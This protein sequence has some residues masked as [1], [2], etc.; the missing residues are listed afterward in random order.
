MPGASLLTA[1]RGWA[2][3]GHVVSM[4]CPPARELAGVLAHLDSP[5]PLIFAGTDTH[6]RNYLAEKILTPPSVEWSVLGDVA[7]FFAKEW[8]GYDRWISGR[9]WKRS[10]E[11][12]SMIDGELLV[13][14][15]DVFDLPADRAVNA[16]LA[17]WRR[18]LSGDPTKW[19]QWIHEV[20]APPPRAVKKA[21]LAK[22]AAERSNKFMELMAVQ[23]EL[24]GSVRPAAADSEIVVE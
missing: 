1:A 22:P 3:D 18:L 7:D 20:Q 4:E 15:V 12:W 2:L 17:I 16:L 8:T 19:K 13:S 10:L 11:A 23:D 24:D 5:L 14:G 21:A 9:I 6:G